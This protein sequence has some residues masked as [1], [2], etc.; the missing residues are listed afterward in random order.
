MA[1]RGIQY[2]NV[3][4][5]ALCFSMLFNFVEITVNDRSDPAVQGSLAKADC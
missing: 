1:N 4:N 5:K 3:Q 2:S